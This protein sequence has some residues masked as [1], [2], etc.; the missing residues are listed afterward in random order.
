MQHLTQQQIRMDDV[1]LNRFHIKIAGLTFGAHF[2]DGYVLGVI[3]FALAQIKPANGPYS[4]LG[5]HARQLGADR[6][7]YG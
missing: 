2:T 1:P 7:V 4:I 5:G 3:G 6:A